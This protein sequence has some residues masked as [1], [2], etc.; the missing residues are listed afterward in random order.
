MIDSTKI[1]TFV[2]TGDRVQISVDNATYVGFVESVSDGSIILEW[3]DTE[4]MSINGK[5]QEG[6]VTK[7]CLLDID[8][9]KDII[10]VT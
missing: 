8:S 5:F 6:M 1:N 3:R 2:E 4:I 10:K 7:R 9:I